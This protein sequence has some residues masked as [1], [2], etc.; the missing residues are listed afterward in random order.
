MKIFESIDSNVIDEAEKAFQSFSQ[1]KESTN[2]SNES[3]SEGMTVVI[4]KKV[5]TENSVSFKS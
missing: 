5:L 4:L 2:D 3:N 1:S